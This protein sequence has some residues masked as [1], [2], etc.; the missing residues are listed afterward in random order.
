MG[1]TATT[2]VKVSGTLAWHC[3]VRGVRM[4]SS[5]TVVP[6]TQQELCSKVLASTG[7][8][9]HWC[10]SMQPQVTHLSLIAR[11]WA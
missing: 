1:L 8:M 9:L 11:C 5:D 4:V 10:T 7:W 6:H 3:Q 2:L